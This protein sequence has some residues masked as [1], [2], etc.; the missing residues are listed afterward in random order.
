MS[1]NRFGKSLLACEHASGILAKQEVFCAGQEG[2]HPDKDDVVRFF[3][4]G[5]TTFVEPV[6]WEDE[7]SLNMKIERA[8]ER[9]SIADRK[10]IVE[11]TFFEPKSEN[12]EKKKGKNALAGDVNDI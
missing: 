4:D 6:G 5:V 11:S 10:E 12:V 1:H 8:L 3:S 7:V 2:W 9:K